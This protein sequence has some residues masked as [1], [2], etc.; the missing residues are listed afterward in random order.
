VAKSKY[1]PNF[2][3][4]KFKELML[5]AAEKSETDE[6]FGATKLN[7][8]LFFSDFLSFGLTGESMTGATYQ[9]L[10][11]GPAPVQLVPEIRKMEKDGDAIIVDRKYFN[12]TQ[13][14]LIPR[15]Q[16][17]KRVFSVDE[18]DLINEVI[19]ALAPYHAG[20]VSKLSHDRSFAWQIARNGEEIPYTA[21][22]LSSRKATPDDIARGK[23]LAGKYGWLNTAR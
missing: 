6:R 22:F 7:K 17:N 16:S 4:E 19:K 15:R 8:I 9:R 2:K 23:E 3:A 12:Y 13:K 18:L 14:R 1:K 11:N 10:K 5:Y 20:E 21:V